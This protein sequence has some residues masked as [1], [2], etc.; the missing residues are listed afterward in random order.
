MHGLPIAF[1]LLLGNQQLSTMNDICS[2]EANQNSALISHTTRSSKDVRLQSEK[3]LH[4]SF[5]HFSREDNESRVTQTS[6]AI[7]LRTHG[8]L[9]ETFR[10]G[11][12]L[13]SLVFN[14]DVTKPLSSSRCNNVDSNANSK[15]NKVMKTHTQQDS[16]NTVIRTANDKP[17]IDVMPTR[18]QSK[19]VP[20]LT[21]FSVLKNSIDFSLFKN[22]PFLLYCIG[23]PM[24]Y[25]GQIAP[26]F[27]LPIRG[28]NCGIDRS[29]SAFLV[30]ILG[31]CNV[32]SRLLWGK[33]SD[34][35]ILVKYKPFISGGTAILDG[36]TSL[37]SYLAK[38]YISFAIFAVM[39]G[40]FSGKSRS[41][42]CND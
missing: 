17:Q 39:W 19:T 18:Q 22:I 3:A 28:V 40:T 12:S 34:I 32:V 13:T 15:L 26:L 41:F 14:K 25:F 21:V 20:C 37:L 24:A 5:V 1:L 4:H 6:S 16:N 8:S 9:V 35:P 2:P 38:D 30:S 11:T 29:S 36:I 31:I 42:L 27:L 23:L 10:L 33:V 7:D